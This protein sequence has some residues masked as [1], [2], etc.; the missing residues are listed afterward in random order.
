V[1]TD[2]EQLYQRT[3]LEHARRPANARAVA[4]TRA[5]RD[6]P[7]CGDEVIVT[8]RVADGRVAEV[9][10]IAEG[11]A[12]SKAAASLLTL[13]VTGRTPGEVRALD[14]RFRALLAGGPDD[15]LGDLGVFAGVARFPV[16]ARCAT[17]AWDALLEAL[18]T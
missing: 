10:A 3:I 5:A 13:A 2:L 9:G 1:T 15:G 8:V 11:C 7:L 14:A 6:N 16:R 4:G 18:A 12:L 17:L